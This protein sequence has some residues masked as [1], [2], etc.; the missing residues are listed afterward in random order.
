MPPLTRPL[1]DRARSSAMNRQRAA[2]SEGGWVGG[3][4]YQ[5]LGP[6]SVRLS[7]RPPPNQELTA[8]SPLDLGGFP[9]ASLLRIRAGLG[10]PGILRAKCPTRP[11]FKTRQFA[12]CCAL[13]VSNLLSLYLTGSCREWPPSD[14]LP[15]TT[16]SPPWSTT[17]RRM[18]RLLR[19][20]GKLPLQSN[21]SYTSLTI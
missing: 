6:P 19:R 15:A 7:T 21:N 3:C 2:A 8:R 12:S 16:R 18:Q 13:S 17:R 4:I 11:N 14:P 10:E 5:D 20:Q 9:P 1:A